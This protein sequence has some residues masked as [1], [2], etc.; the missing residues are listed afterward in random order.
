MSL[1][2][3]R[4]TQKYFLFFNS[5]TPSR[6]REWIMDKYT[7]EVIEHFTN[8][9]KSFSP[10]YDK[11]KEVDEQLLNNY[12]L[13][14]QHSSQAISTNCYSLFKRNKLKRRL[15]TGLDNSKWEYYV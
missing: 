13:S 8:Y 12:L 5:G 14:F 3:S 4:L 10:H 7:E 2:W 9:I 15:N 6:I 1:I 11:F